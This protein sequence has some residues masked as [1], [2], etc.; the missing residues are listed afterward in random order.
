MSKLTI[1]MTLEQACQYHRH[2]WPRRI[3]PKTDN[4]LTI[5]DFDPGDEIRIAILRPS[6]VLIESDFVRSTLEWSI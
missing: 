1:A 6:N 2:N 5:A 3:Q 4:C